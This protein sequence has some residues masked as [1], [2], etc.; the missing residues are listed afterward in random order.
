[1]S[2]KQWK[3]QSRNSRRIEL[4]DFTKSF[5]M[6]S[7]A[8]ASPTPIS[9]NAHK[10]TSSNFGIQETPRK[11][12][13]CKYYISNKTSDTGV[14][15]WG[16]GKEGELG[17][18]SNSD[19]DMPRFIEALNSIQ[20]R[21]IAC[22][23][24]H[25]LILTSTNTIYSWGFNVVGQLGLGDFIDR[26]RPCLLKSIQHIPI[27]KICSGAGHCFAISSKGYLF[28]WGSGGYYQ[29]CTGSQ[30]NLNRP[31][32]MDE[33][34]MIDDVS[35]GIAHTLIL[36]SDGSVWSVGL[37]DS[38]QCGF[39][40]TE[41]ILKPRVID[42]LKNVKVVKLA[43]GG[44]HSMFLLESG[45]IMSCGLNSCGQLGVNTYESHSYVPSIVK[46]LKESK[47]SLMALYQKEALYTPLSNI[48]NIY[49]GEEVSAA[50]DSEYRLYV[51]GWNGGG[52]LGQGHFSDVLLPVRLEIDEKVMDVCCGVSS[53]A[54]ITQSNILYTCGYIG[55]FKIFKQNSIKSPEHISSV[56]KLSSKF[57]R[58]IPNDIA[59]ARP[60]PVV[61]EKFRS[62]AV[63]LGRTH[64]I[65]TLEMI[66][67]EKSQDSIEF[68]EEAVNFITY[69]NASPNLTY[70]N[71]WEPLPDILKHERK[72]SLNMQPVMEIV[73]NPF[74]RPYKSG[75]RQQ[76]RKQ[77]IERANSILTSYRFEFRQKLAEKSAEYAKFRRNIDEKMELEK[78]EIMERI[79]EEKLNLPKQKKPKATRRCSTQDLKSKEKLKLLKIDD[80]M[81][82]SPRTG[83]EI[84]KYRG[85]V[86][87]YETIIQRQI[88]QNSQ[89][90]ASKTVETEKLRRIGG[91]F[92]RHNNL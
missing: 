44:S 48:I 3:F 83:M 79:K 13:G 61:K 73:T 67:E 64:I 58:F 1:M 84:D 14:Y 76:S 24:G 43:A 16:S 37:N 56:R 72:V 53:L 29:N 57:A 39:Q 54:F 78:Q 36:K 71:D 47:N 11:S 5:Q 62:N 88:V 60:Q 2:I 19:E 17:H 12:P 63:A 10:I 77:N 38:G 80:F 40:D 22:G 81:K 49:A 35:G 46:I 33:L 86:D 65:C 20:V 18:G 68:E 7:S 75:S 28:A 87:K 91:G 26:N 69:R 23:A 66:P 6:S 8:F 34:G 9:L 85:L 92:I 50:L 82:N 74:R 41:I 45:E 89:R 27:E 32:R 30:D 15:S 52:Q 51:W 25:S 31:L 55:E 70:D 59:L 42:A 4:K 90:Q 21:Q